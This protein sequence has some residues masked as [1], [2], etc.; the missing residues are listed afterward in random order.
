MNYL[1]SDPA[2]LKID[3]KINNYNYD[4]L[5][6]V[7]D[8]FDVLFFNYYLNNL[9]YYILKNIWNAVVK[10]WILM[11]NEMK[12]KDESYLQ[13]EYSKQKYNHI[14]TIIDCEELNLLLTNFIDNDKF[15]AIF[16][17]NCIINH[18]I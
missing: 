8:N 10:K 1:K 7:K 2:K 12:T 4:F 17:A 9:E 13:S 14:H 15:K 3:N 6:I 5:D 11:G 18:Y 16:V